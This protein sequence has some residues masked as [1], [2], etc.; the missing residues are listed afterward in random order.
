MDRLSARPVPD[1]EDTTTNYWASKFCLTLRE[2]QDT[3]ILGGKVFIDETFYKLR[4]EDI[5]TR[6][7][8]LQYRGLSCIGIGCDLCQ[9]N[10]R[11]PPSY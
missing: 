8:G 10:G 1:A 9:D 2:C 11:I 3:I 6:E 4:K 5:Q 7:D